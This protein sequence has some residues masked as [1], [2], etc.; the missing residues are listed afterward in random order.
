[1]FRWQQLPPYPYATHHTP[2]T[3]HHIPYIPSIPYPI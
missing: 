3:T 2:H 1:M